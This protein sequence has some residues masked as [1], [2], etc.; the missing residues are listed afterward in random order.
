MDAEEELVEAASWSPNVS[1]AAIV[2][3]DFGVYFNFAQMLYRERSSAEAGLGAFGR[4]GYR[5][6]DVNR[7]TQFASTHLRVPKPRITV[8][9]YRYL[10]D[11]F[12]Q[13]SWGGAIAIGFRTGR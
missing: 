6:P 12:K 5:A 10:D 4:Y 11:R 13:E 2:R 3:E 9:L 7:I 1:C 8:L